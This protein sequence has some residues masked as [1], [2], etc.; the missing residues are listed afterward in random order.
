MVFLDR[1]EIQDYQDQQDHQEIVDQEDNEVC[2]NK[3]SESNKNIVQNGY[4]SLCGSAVVFT[5][6]SVAT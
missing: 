5:V 6:C 2:E 4:K 3:I 1:K